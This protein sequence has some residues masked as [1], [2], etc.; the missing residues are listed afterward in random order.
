M[1][2]LVWTSVSSVLLWKGYSGV[3]TCRAAFSSDLSRSE[4]GPRRRLGHF[5]TFALAAL[6]LAITFTLFCSS[7][8]DSHAHQARLVHSKRQ[9]NS[10]GAVVAFGGSYSDNGHARA[11]KY[12]SLMTGTPC[13]SCSS[14]LKVRSG[15]PTPHASGRKTN[16]PTSVEHLATSLNAQ[17][18][19]CKLLSLRPRARADPA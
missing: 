9:S 5:D 11:A 17:L 16:G 3:L 19:N 12:S 6:T 13:E 18:R 4:S 7:F 1:L 14:R 8:A 2:G 10:V 15:P